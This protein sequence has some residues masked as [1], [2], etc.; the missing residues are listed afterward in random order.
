MKVEGNPLEELDVVN[1]L[2]ELPATE[3]TEQYTQS[4]LE[5]MVG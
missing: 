4:R 2:K 3:E 1:I 5:C